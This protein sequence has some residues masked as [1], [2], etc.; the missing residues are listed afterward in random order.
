MKRPRRQ[1]LQLAATA[2]ALP[3]VS[4]IARAQPYPTRPIM[5]IVPYG[6]GG[7]T[8]TVGR[9]I[10]EGMRGALGQSIIVENVAGASA[11][12]GVGRAAR[13]AGDGYTLGIGNWSSHVLNGAIFAL[14][15]DLLRDFEP[16][17]HIASDPQLI[18]ARKDMPT[19]NLSELIAWLRTNPDK[20]SQGTGG[21]G[22]TSHVAGVFFQKE[23]NTRFQFVP[24]RLGVGAAMQDLIAGHIDMMFSVAANA[25]PQLRAGT[26]KG[27][28]VTAKSRLAV[29]HEIPTVHEAGLPGFYIS[30]W[31]GLWVPKATPN[32]VIGTLNAAVVVALADPTVRQRLADL[33]QEIPARN[34]QTPEALAELQTAEIE[35]WWPIVREAGIKPD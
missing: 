33:G 6:A 34:Q 9:I 3:T 7:P 5:M 1:F 20:A 4:R 8:D 28:A 18:I 19:D 26:I 15:Y 31:H 22:S 30:N 13:A 14:Q 2:A 29:A 21:A 12:I 32:T 23:T 16:I 17:A 35:K 24:Y 10:A 25:V 27:Y 11:T